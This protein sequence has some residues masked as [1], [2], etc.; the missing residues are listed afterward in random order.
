MA[1]FT[2]VTIAPR[3][4][5]HVR[6]FDEIKL[7]LYA[8]LLALGHEVILRTN[9][10]EESALNIIF[11]AHL[12]SE[13]AIESIPQGSIIFNTE[14]LGGDFA[15]WSQKVV[16]LADRHRV[17]D[18]SSLNLEALAQASSGLNSDRLKRFRLGFHPRLQKIARSIGD[19][20]D[21]FVFFGSLTRQ[22]EDI[23]GRIRLSERLYL[24]V[25]FGFYGYRRDAILR[26]SRAVLNIHSHPVRILEW[27]RILYLIANRIPVIA[28]IHEST[29]AEDLQLSYVLAC[30]EDDPTPKLESYY[31]QPTL[32]R[33]H[34]EAAFS[35][36][37]EEKQ[38]IFT[39]QALD[40]LLGSAFLPAPAMAPL[41]PPHGWSYSPRQRS[42]DPLW[43]RYTYFWI[44]ADPRPVEQVHWDVGVYRQCHPDPAFAAEVFRPPIVLPEQG[45]GKTL[46][47]EVSQDGLP[48]CAV[49]LHFYSELRVCSFFVNF[50]RHFPVGTHFLITASTRSVRALVEKVAADCGIS[51]IEVLLV[52]NVGRDIPS[53]YIL[54]NEKLADYEL[55]F[56]SHGKESDDHWFHDHNNLL[57]GSPERIDAIRTL[58]AQDESLGL[59]FPDYLSHLLPSIG[60]SDLRA[61]IDS[62]LQGFGCDTA[63]VEV[64]EF[65]AGGFYWARPA[66]LTILHSLGLTIADLPPE[67]L[68]RDNTLLHALERMP[69]LST[70]MM[71]L[72]WEKV[73]RSSIPG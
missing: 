28:L 5:Q 36:F 55:C 21:G 11:G 53:K 19:D 56:F 18:Y 13:D 30:P 64:L 67:P 72:R 58:F 33:E 14:Q 8:S 23:I 69:C 62:L 65:P 49:V 35:R 57:A 24:H 66:A 38:V 73:A 60:W 3:H 39:E 25:Y 20:D 32:L 1:R 46:T 51:N 37:R 10:F 61:M 12:I 47:S 41:A 40:E 63:P 17:W 27:P 70:E 68:A 7:L 2:I 4:Y 54:F 59:L 43:Y 6:A 22:R 31:A 26:R 9:E 44:D 48:R 15:E 52:D 34:A 50:G 45:C 42:P 16:R 29:C 71:G